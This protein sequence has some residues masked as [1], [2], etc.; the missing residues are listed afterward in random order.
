MQSKLFLTS[1]ESIKEKLIVEK[2]KVQISKMFKKV[3]FKSGKM[4]LILNKN[5]TYVFLRE[6]LYRILILY[7]I[8][9]WH[10]ILIN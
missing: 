5:N 6:H 1:L 4:D 2:S 8:V 7:S 3:K 9:F 10:I